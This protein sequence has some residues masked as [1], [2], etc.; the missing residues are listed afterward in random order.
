MVIEVLLC[1]IL[2]FLFLQ[3][4]WTITTSN[5]HIWNVRIVFVGGLLGIALKYGVIFSLLYFGGFFD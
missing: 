4:I 5:D 1:I 3:E 2:I